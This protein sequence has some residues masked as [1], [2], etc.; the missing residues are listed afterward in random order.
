MGPSGREPALTF[1]REDF[2]LPCARQLQRQ[3]FSHSRADAVGRWAGVVL[4][5]QAFARHLGVAG[6]AAAVAQLG[7]HLPRESELTVLG[8]RVTLEARPFMARPEPFVEHGQCGVDERDGVAGGQDETV[9]EAQPR[10]AHVPSHSPRQGERQH[11]VDL[12]ARPARVPALAVIE[13]QVYALV[14]KVL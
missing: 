14:D 7:Q 10:P 2:Y 6:E 8:E 11:H 13:R 5:E 4:E 9:G 12:R 1:D 3:S